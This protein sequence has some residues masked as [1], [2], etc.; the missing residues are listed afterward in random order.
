MTTMCY[1]GKPN[2]TLGSVVPL[3][4]FFLQFH[5]IAIGPSSLNFEED[6]F[7]S[8][9]LEFTKHTNIGIMLVVWWRL[10]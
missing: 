10:W 4:M 7:F 1:H 6:L 8:F 3:E 2:S 9:G 5:Y